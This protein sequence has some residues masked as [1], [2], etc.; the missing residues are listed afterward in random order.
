M[1]KLLSFAHR[2]AGRRLRVRFFRPLRIEQ[3][4]RRLLLANS[5][6]VWIT[7]SA[8][9]SEPLGAE[10]NPVQR[11][12]TLVVNDQDAGQ[13]LTFRLV[14]TGSCDPV[15]STYPFTNV[16]GLPASVMSVGGNVN[17]AADLRFNVG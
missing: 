7:T 10:V 17:E 8:V 12:A 16:V 11:S 15:I 2:L 14:G 3:F 13:T 5:P 4:E 1:F 9:V 6:P